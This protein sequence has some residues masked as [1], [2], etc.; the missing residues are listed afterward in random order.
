MPDLKKALVM[1]ANTLHHSFTWVCMI[2]SCK[3]CCPW[4]AIFNGYCE[5]N[6]AVR[7]LSAD[8]VQLFVAPVNTAVPHM[9]F[10]LLTLTCCCSQ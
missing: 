8:P 3:C 5:S 9:L 7:T 1:F 10:L 6:D 2:K 4:L